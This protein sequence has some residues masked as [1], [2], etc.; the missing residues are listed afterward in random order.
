MVRL[1]RAA[2]GQV[3][4]DQWLDTAVSDTYWSEYTN[5]TTGAAG[6]VIG[7]STT[8]PTTDRWTMAAVELVNG[9]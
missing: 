1:S 5:Q 2:T 9:G 6:S 4:L 8:A 7:I 3:P